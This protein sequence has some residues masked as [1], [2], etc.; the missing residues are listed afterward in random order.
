[1]CGSVEEVRRCGEVCWGVEKVEGKWGGVWREGKWGGVGKWS[2]V[3]KRREVW[4]S[5][6]G[7]LERSG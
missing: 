1:M 5:V 2:G 7:S 6:G 3:G 4:E